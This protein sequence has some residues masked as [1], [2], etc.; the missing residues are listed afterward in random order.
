MNS[1]LTS[2]SMVSTGPSVAATCSRRPTIRNAENNRSIVVY[3]WIPEQH[4]LL[5]AGNDNIY[6]LFF[7]GHVRQA[8]LTIKNNTTSQL[9]AKAGVLFIYLFIANYPC[10]TGEFQWLRYCEWGI[11]ASA[12]QSYSIHY[13][14]LQ[15]FSLTWFYV[16]IC[17]NVKRALPLVIFFLRSRGEKKTTFAL[18]FSLF[19]FPS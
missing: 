12:E 4:L 19:F 6:V 2:K 3:R 7:P 17:I 8:A 18:G 1:A 9:L 13:H 5:L 15:L 14:L 11:P 16:Y 10:D